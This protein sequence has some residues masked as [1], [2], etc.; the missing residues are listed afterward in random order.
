[1]GSG[2]AL[3]AAAALSILSLHGHAHAQQAPA[4]R[5]TLPPLASR[6]D[7]VGRLPAIEAVAQSLRHCQGITVS[8]AERLACYEQIATAVVPP[9]AQTRSVRQFAWAVQAPAD[10]QAQEYQATLALGASE[11][12]AG[13]DI[14]SRPEATLVLRCRRPEVSAYVSFPIKVS[15]APVPVVLRYDGNAAAAATW[16]HSVSGSAVGMWYNQEGARGLARRLLDV[17]RMSAAFS[18][19]DGKTVTVMFE[20]DGYAGV[21]ESA[22]RACGLR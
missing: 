8:P 14:F 18:L 19:P 17:K 10:P 15:A 21:P 1:M 7:A 5:P 2:H 6:E 22:L 4:P 20:V 3:W 13:D 16:E 12:V 9:P 11:V